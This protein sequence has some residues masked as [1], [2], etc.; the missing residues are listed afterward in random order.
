MMERDIMPISR[1]ARFSILYTEQDFATIKAQKNK[2][3]MA[4]LLPALL[5]LAAIVY[6][7]ILRLEWLT[8]LLTILL[9]AYLI[10]MHGIYLAPVAAYYQHLNQVMHGRT[11]K[12][13]GAFK[14]MEETAVYR[15]GVRYYAMLVNVGR[16]EDEEDDRLLYFDANLPRPDWK[17]GDM[18]TFTHHDKA[19]GAWEK[20]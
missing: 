6:S 7:L 11:R 10:F 8:V 12:L 5:M 14:E 13:T 15:E 19:V 1:K 16:M 4:V 2:R 20:A 17:K 18:I 3:Q 9:G